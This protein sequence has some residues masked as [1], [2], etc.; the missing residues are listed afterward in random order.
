MMSTLADRQ[1]LAYAARSLDPGATRAVEE[2][3]AANP[4]LRRRL[5]ALELQMDALQGQR[6]WHLPV[7]ALPIGPRR[8]RWSS[9]G[10]WPWGATAPSATSDPGTTS[11]SASRRLETPAIGDR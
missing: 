4:D 6:R 1:L 9:T 11:G 2:A 7:V 5:A 3:F 10:R 8:W